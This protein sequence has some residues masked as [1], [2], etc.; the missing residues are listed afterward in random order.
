MLE[1]MFGANQSATLPPSLL[2]FIFSPQVL[3]GSIL[4]VISPLCLQKQSQ[5]II[6]KQI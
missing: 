4:S 5:L 2:I 3:E 6:I 1:T